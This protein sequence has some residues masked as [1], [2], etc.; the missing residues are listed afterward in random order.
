MFSPHLLPLIFHSPVISSECTRYLPFRVKPPTSCLFSPTQHPTPSTSTSPPP[1]AHPPHSP[2]CNF[3]GQAISSARTQYWLCGGKILISAQSLVLC[4][5]APQ[6]LHQ[7]HYIHTLHPLR[8]T[9]HCY[10]QYRVLRAISS[11]LSLACSLHPQPSL[12]VLI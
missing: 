3:D 7:T 4:L 8:F 9:F 5:P 10:G 1:F 2:P 6:Q 12:P 11:N